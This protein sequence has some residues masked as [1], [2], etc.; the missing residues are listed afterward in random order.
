MISVSHS[1]IFRLLIAPAPE[2]ESHS[3]RSIRPPLL[4]G[5]RRLLKPAVAK[6]WEPQ[7]RAAPALVDAR[8]AF[9]TVLAKQIFLEISPALDCAFSFLALA[10]R[11]LSWFSLSS[12]SASL[13]VI[14]LASR[15]ELCGRMSFL[16]SL[17][18]WESATAIWVC[19]LASASGSAI[20]PDRPLP[21]T[22]L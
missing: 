20:H 17:S 12:S 16:P 5:R 3:Q 19:V 21:L 14:L 1:R 13:R 9:Q 4:L 22:S 7:L 2:P 6:D 11:Q 8:S 10:S 15:K 18:V